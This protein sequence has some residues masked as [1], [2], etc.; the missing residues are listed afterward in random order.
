MVHDGCGLLKD[1]ALAEAVPEAASVLLV[2]IVTEIDDVR[3]LEALSMRQRSSSHC[4]AR[5]LKMCLT[6][7][8]L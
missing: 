1:A 4:S 7:M 8:C 3:V 6:S 5:S 2:V